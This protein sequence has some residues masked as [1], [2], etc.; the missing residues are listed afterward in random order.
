[1]ISG[2]ADIWTCAFL[3]GRRP[4]RGKR[5]ASRPIASSC[6]CSSPPSRSP[7][8]NQRCRTHCAPTTPLC[9]PCRTSSPGPR[10]G[11]RAQIRPG[12]CFCEERKLPSGQH[13]FFL[14]HEMD[15]DM[16][17]PETRSF[18]RMKP[19]QNGEWCLCWSQERLWSQSFNLQTVRFQQGDRTGDPHF[20]A[21]TYSF[22]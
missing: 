5:S 18:E 4:R 12:R 2:C 21:F 10:T 13:D 16:F 15:N 22:Y 7:W 8:A 17:G 20:Y 11:N 6:S 1:M 19:P 14:I 3:G 9:T